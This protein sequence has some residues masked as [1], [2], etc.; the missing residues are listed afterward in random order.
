MI[1]NERVAPLLNG[2][3]FICAEGRNYIFVARPL[4]PWYLNESCL[5]PFYHFAT[6]IFAFLTLLK[7]EKMITPLHKKR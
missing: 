3:T 5:N 1:D 4:S 7:K 6:C 2:T